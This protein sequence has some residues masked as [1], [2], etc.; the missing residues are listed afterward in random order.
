[1]MVLP[2]ATAPPSGTPSLCPLEPSI[3]STL[4]PLPPPSFIPLPPPLHFP[5]LPLASRALLP[6][7]AILP[8][9]ELL[10]LLALLPPLL[11]LHPQ[12]SQTGP[13]LKASLPHQA[14]RILCF[15]A[16]L[17]LPHKPAPKP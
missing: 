5:H 15:H 12:R 13:F 11:Y 7:L 8:L 1:M 10:P 9:L 17:H 4:S 14:N 16:P 2:G 3:R 6:L